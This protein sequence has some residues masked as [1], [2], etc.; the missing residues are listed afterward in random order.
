MLLSIYLNDHLAGATAGRD[1]ARRAAGSNRHSSYGPFLSQVAIEIDEDRDT[2]LALMRAL[3]VGVD[4]LKVIGGWTLEKLG[5]L[6]PNGRLFSYSP[7]SRLVELEGLTLGVTGKLS[8][9][10]ALQEMRS[11]YPALADFDLDGLV[12]RARRQV[13]GLESNRRRAAAEALGR[14]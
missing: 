6:K 2:L 9:W 1:L 8:M 7:L 3:G 10:L 12:A 4:R 5:R 11:E 13:E 14:S